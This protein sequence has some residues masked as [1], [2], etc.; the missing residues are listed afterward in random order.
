M[1]RIIKSPVVGLLSSFMWS[2]NSQ[3]QCYLESMPEFVGRT[4]G[5]VAFQLPDAIAFGIVNHFRWDLHLW[6][7]S[8]NKPTCTWSICN[9]V[10][11]AGGHSLPSVP[12]AASGNARTYARIQCVL[13]QQT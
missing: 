9:F 2:F 7:R 11:H 8:A 5:S 10:Q 12:C 1:A 3:S 6:G 4:F 13:S